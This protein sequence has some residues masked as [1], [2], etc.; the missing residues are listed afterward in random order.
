M[1]LCLCRTV[2]RRLPE[3]VDL[4]LVSMHR[5]T[6]LGVWDEQHLG[7]KSVFVWSPRNI[8]AIVA[9]CVVRN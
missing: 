9:A 6:L 4:R 1:L 5:R 7:P 2:Q 3:D 8:I